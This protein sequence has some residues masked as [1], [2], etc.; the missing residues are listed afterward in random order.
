MWDRDRVAVAAVSLSNN[1][2]NRYSSSILRVKP[3]FDM[4]NFEHWNTQT[5]ITSYYE[6]AINT[7]VCMYVCVM[8]VLMAFFIPIVAVNNLKISKP[9]WMQLQQCL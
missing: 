9:N 1:T 2:L 5:S 7:H 4:G 6:V 3:L 8:C